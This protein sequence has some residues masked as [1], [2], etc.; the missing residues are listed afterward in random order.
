MK[1]YK[2]S[3]T[4][5]NGQVV[6]VFWQQDIWAAPAMEVSMVIGK[7]ISDN[8]KWFND[9]INFSSVKSTGNCGLEGLLFALSV[10]KD[11]QKQYDLTIEWMD[12]KRERAYA[13]L[14]R[15]GFRYGHYTEH[16][17]VKCLYW[18]K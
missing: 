16:P 2:S 18:I 3:K 7:S 8:K 5:S 1:Y 11:L 15:L 6:T 10:I 14:E 13:Y 9:H 12:G 4:L 17:E